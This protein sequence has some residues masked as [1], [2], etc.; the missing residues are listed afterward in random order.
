ML[1][2]GSLN[3]HH[4][5]GNLNGGGPLARVQTGSGDAGF[6]VES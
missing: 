2:K 3:Q 6:F 1:V 5:T 4:L